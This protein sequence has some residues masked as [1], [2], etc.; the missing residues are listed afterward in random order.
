M[1]SRRARVSSRRVSYPPEQM[2][3]AL[4]AIK[5]EPVYDDRVAHLEEMMLDRGLDAD[6]ARRRLGKPGT[7]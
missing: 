3:E 4:R 5:L 1:A 2:L 6:L 7:M